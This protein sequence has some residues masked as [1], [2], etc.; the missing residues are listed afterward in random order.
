MHGT[1]IPT[2]IQT[3]FIFHPRA[4]LP[5][6]LYEDETD[7]AYGITVN[8]QEIIIL[9]IFSDYKQNDQHYKRFD[10]GV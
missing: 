3:Y 9:I 8:L 6:W 1:A 10:L 5:E 2:S 7:C 4:T